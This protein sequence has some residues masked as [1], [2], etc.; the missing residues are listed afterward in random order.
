M[1]FI[2]FCIIFTKNYEIN[3][4]WIANIRKFFKKSRLCYNRRFCYNNT[5]KEEIVLFIEF[6]YKNKNLSV[7]SKPF[8]LANFVN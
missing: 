6:P 7:F 8:V 1:I 5:S 4:F 3:Y 2:L